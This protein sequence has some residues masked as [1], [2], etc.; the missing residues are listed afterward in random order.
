M[1]NQRV[2][3]NSVW[4]HEALAKLDPFR[5]VAL[6]PYVISWEE[7]YKRAVDYVTKVSGL[8]P[9]RRSIRKTLHG[10]VLEGP[11]KSSSIYVSC[12]DGIIRKTPAGFAVYPY[13][14]NTSEVIYTMEIAQAFLRDDPDVVWDKVME[15]Y[16]KIQL[17]K[18][19]YTFLSESTF[20]ITLAIACRGTSL[21][22]AV[23]MAK[24]H[25]YGLDEGDFFLDVSK[26]T[27]LVDQLR[28]P[29]NSDLRVILKFAE[30]IGRLP[31]SQEEFLSGVP[32]CTQIPI[33]PEPVPVRAWVSFDDDI[34][35]NINGSATRVRVGSRDKELPTSLLYHFSRLKQE[36]HKDA[37]LFF[38]GLG[39]GDFSIAL[40]HQLYETWL[41]HGSPSINTL[42]TVDKII[43]NM[44]PN[45]KVTATMAPDCPNALACTIMG[46]APGSPSKTGY[47]PL[48]VPEKMLL[49]WMLVHNSIPTKRPLEAMRQ[50][51]RDKMD[52]SARG[53][54]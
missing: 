34:Q 27:F 30:T 18:G 7:T 39:T 24:K 9:G 3:P 50:A 15:G 36:A 51:T 26:E 54:R 11:E 44:I 25:H 10:V 12:R 5:D 23:G 20:P 2:N 33:M 17:N 37:L 4:S 1:G 40:R 8:D 41:S 31:V 47:I 19:P 32:R 38:T 49:S 52:E 21:D 35:L 13:G 48:D 42:R 53:E 14:L 22:E 16:K 29:L 43:T 6:R 28:I 46:T 45:A